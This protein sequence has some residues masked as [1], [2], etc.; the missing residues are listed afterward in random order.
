MADMAK[1]LGDAVDALSFA[2]AKHPRSAP[3]PP[4]TGGGGRVT[5][6]TIA[7]NSCDRATREGRLTYAHIL[8]EEAAEVLAETDPVKLR[9][10]LMH[11]MA[12][13]LRWV[14]ELDEEASLRGGVALLV[15]VGWSA[16]GHTSI[17]CTC[18]ALI[19]QCRCMGPK[20]TEIAKDGCT[21]CRRP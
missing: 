17:V 11:V 3:L 14:E 12:V 5:W 9:T 4:G 7:R 1:I 13:C 2:K 20:K 15:G 8:D 6:M 10:E 16:C 19:A 18:G 21:N